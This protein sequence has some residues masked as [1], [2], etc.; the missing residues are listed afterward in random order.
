MDNIS[1]LITEWKSEI[2]SITEDYKD[3]FGKLATKELNWKPD[4]KTWTIG[5]NIEHVIR[6][7][8]SYF[9]VLKQLTDGT[10]RAPLLGKC[11]FVPSLLGKVILKAVAP[12]RKKK[13]K[14]VTIWEPSASHIDKDIIEKFEK[15]QHEL[16]HQMEQSECFLKKGTIISSPA[17]KNI[18]YTLEKAFEIIIN[19]EKRHYHQANELLALMK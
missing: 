13:I 8:E 19:H 5:Q 9:P 14:T 7:N 3:A 1:T 2:K 6:I 11:P 4:P 18:V 16:V 12:D 10:Y 15:H 17:N